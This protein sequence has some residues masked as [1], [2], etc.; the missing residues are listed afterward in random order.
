MNKDIS[1]TTL[2]NKTMITSK[3][4]NKSIVLDESGTEI[5]KL[6]LEE[7]S[8]E[9]I[10]NILSEKYSGFDEEIKTDVNEFFE[11]L[12]KYEII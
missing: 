4:S 3:K 5:W 6:I 10:I 2:D 7:K 11:I 12:I 9:E 1:F 8:K